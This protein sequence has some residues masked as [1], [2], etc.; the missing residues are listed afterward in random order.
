[1]VAVAGE[2][3]NSGNNVVREHLPMVFPPLLNIDNHDLLQP[4]SVL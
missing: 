2:Y 1:V 3:Q 4:E